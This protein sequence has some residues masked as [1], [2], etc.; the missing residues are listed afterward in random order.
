MSQIMNNQLNV[1]VFNFVDMLSHARTDSKMIRE[2][3]SDDGLPFPSPYPGSSTL[4]FWIFQTSG[5]QRSKIIIT[6]DHGNHKVNNAIKVVGDR[7]TNTNL[8]YKEGKT[9]PI[10]PKKCLL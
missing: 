6:T 5:R 7:N 10:M 9:W 2:L 4:P 1:V 8:R 3:A